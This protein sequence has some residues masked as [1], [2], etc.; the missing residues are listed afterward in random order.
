MAE[1]PNRISITKSRIDEADWRQTFP[2]PCML[3]EYVKFTKWLIITHKHRPMHL[4]HFQCSVSFWSLQS[5][6]FVS[7]A[8]DFYI[9]KCDGIWFE[10]ISKQSLINRICLLNIRGN[11]SRFLLK[12]SV[13]LP[14]FISVD[15]VIKHL[16]VFFIPDQWR[17]QFVCYSRRVEVCRFISSSVRMEPMYSM[18][19]HLFCQ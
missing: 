3:P 12:I 6:E 16:I 5:F 1:R 14:D 17:K 4:G 18:S 19:P 15:H 10:K 2:N 13:E 8:E 9:I 11:V 7:C